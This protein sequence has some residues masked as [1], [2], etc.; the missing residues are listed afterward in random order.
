MVVNRRASDWSTTYSQYLARSAAVSAKTASLCQLVLERIAQGQLPATV[1]QDR[2]PSFLV[3]HGSRFTNQFS[4]IFSRFLSRLIELGLGLGR[5]G[6]DAPVDE[7][8]EP[9]PP[10]FDSTNPASWYAELADY[11]GQLN[12]RAIRAYRAQ[13][14]QVAAGETSPGEAQRHTAQQMAQRLPDFMQ[15]ITGLYFELLDELNDVRAQYEEAYFHHMLGATG[16]PAEAPVALTLAGPAGT[17][18]SASLSI[19]N[20]TDRPARITHR[21]LEARRVDGVGPALVPAVL[22]SPDGLELGPDEEATVELGLE[23]D[24]QRFDLDALYAGVL[25]FNGAAD[26]PLQV[27]LRIRVSPPVSQQG[28]A[29]T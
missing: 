17:T 1:F 16:Q 28:Q 2:L 19:T 10:H 6:P 7:A 29:R 8:A 26:V 4:E 20:T 13:L 24:P 23:L 22:V 14:D 12:A 9:L 11:A 5:G 25:H 15:T 21:V 18:A 3:A 27:E